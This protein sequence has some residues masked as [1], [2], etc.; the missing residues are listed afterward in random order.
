MVFKGYNLINPQLTVLP[1]DF[2]RLETWHEEI[3]DFFWESL[4]KSRSHTKIVQ[5]RTVRAFI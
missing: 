3:R 4:H 2:I 5:T 1:L